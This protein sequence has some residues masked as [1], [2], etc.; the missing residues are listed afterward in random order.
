MNA[1]DVVGYAYE[2]S[3]YCTDCITAVVPNPNADDSDASPV[4]A[5]SETDS[6]SHCTT[7]GELIEENLTT[8]G[9]AYVAEEVWDHVLSGGKTGS[10]DVLRTWM[11][12]YRGHWPEAA[13]LYDF[14]RFKIARGF[15]LVAHYAH[16][17]QGSAEYA[18]HSALSRIRYEPRGADEFLPD[19]F[20]GGDEQDMANYLLYL[21]QPGKIR[22][23]R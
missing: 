2:A 11:D 12:Y 22:D 4:F 20:G 18:L 14:D 9:Y 15:Y 8:E 19:L 13:P 23:R 1:S 10:A 7:C 16:A 21:M 5:D 3:M 6:P 17:G